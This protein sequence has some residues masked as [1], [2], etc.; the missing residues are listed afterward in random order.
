MINMKIVGTRVAN[1]L[2]IRGTG[3]LDTLF[4]VQ[5]D[6]RRLCRLQRINTRLTRRFRHLRALLFRGVTTGAAG[7]V[8]AMNFA[9]PNRRFHRHRQLFPRTRGLRG[10]NVGAGGVTKRTGIRRVAI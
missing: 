3:T 9:Q 8:R 7:R 10:T 2:S 6:G 4:R 5:R 1:S